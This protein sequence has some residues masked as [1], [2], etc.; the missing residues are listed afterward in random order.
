MVLSPLKELNDENSTEL[1]EYLSGWLRW[2]RLTATP[3]EPRVLFLRP[4]PLTPRHGFIDSRP[5]DIAAED[6]GKYTEVVYSLL[7]EIQ[8]EDKDGELIIQPMVNAKYSAVVCGENISFG[9]GNDGVT[10]GKGETLTL[11]WG[12]WILG[13]SGRSIVDYVHRLLSDDFERPYMGELVS[14]DGRKWTAVQ[15]REVSGTLTRTASQFIPKDMTVSIIIDTT[16]MSPLNLQA[17]LV[18]NKYPPGALFVVGT[19]QSHQAC[20]LVELGY[21]VVTGG[22]RDA[23]K[24]KVGSHLTKTRR[25]RAASVNITAL[26][27]E[28]H[29]AMS[30]WKDIRTSHS[31]TSL[32]GLA[33]ATAKSSYSLL[34]DTP[35]QRRVVAFG[36]AS[37]FRLTSMACVGEARHYWAWGGGHRLMGRHPFSSTCPSS[38]PAGREV[39]YAQGMSL[40]NR[41][42][43]YNLMIADVLF[44]MQSWEE[45]AFIYNPGTGAVGYGGKK[46]LQISSTALTFYSILR[47]FL[48]KPS[49]AQWRKVAAAA[50]NLSMLVHNGGTGPLSK[51]GGDTVGA[52]TI[53]KL[54]KSTF[55]IFPTTHLVK[56]RHIRLNHRVVVRGDS[57][58]WLPLPYKQGE[59]RKAKLCLPAT[60][61]RSSGC[62]KALKFPIRDASLCTTYS[63]TRH[64]RH[65]SSCPGLLAL[66]VASDSRLVNTYVMRSAVWAVPFPEGL[67]LRPMKPTYKNPAGLGEPTFWMP[68][69]A[70]GKFSPKLMD[71]QNASAYIN[72]G[73]IEQ[74]PDGFIS[75]E[76]IAQRILD[77]GV[78]SHA[79]SLEELDEA[80]RTATYIGLEEDSDDESGKT[81]DEEAH[82]FL[83]GIEDDND[84]N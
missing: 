42:M 47:A 39:V 52:D 9:F 37:L 49:C 10:G 76:D 28:L 55:D 31:M 8:Q 19:M 82:D 50:N 73:G 6:W 41:Q 11:P 16:L 84:G 43:V 60:Y 25:H 1:T 4:A 53:I 7:R 66:W 83:A 77:V 3:N 69:A 70:L 15:A 51:F 64:N 54:M 81:T 71:M 14:E 59:A 2:H 74:F 67:A 24:Y 72:V 56:A 34:L 30:S 33:S 36:L 62:W 61:D 79:P 5:L 75:T 68:R 58:P 12:H 44:S 26:A 78:G 21:P 80:F 63:V 45:E 23:R 32:A 40:S 48:H 13:H 57:L 20:Q 27:S 29:K 65:W 17:R 35:G 38:A 46:W 18:K 22:E